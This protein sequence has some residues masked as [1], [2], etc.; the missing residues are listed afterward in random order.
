MC[1]PGYFETC[2]VVHA[3]LKHRYLPVFAP[4][5]LGLRAG[6]MVQGLR[7]QAALSEVVSSIS[8]NQVLGLKQWAPNLAPFLFSLIQGPKPGTAHL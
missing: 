8:K 3:S 1:N 6:E 4:Q 7:A 5:V 2:C